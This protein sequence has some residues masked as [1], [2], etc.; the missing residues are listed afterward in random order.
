MPCLRMPE[1]PTL[2]SLHTLGL[3]TPEMRRIR[4]EN[5][6]ESHDIP[7]V[8]R[9]ALDVDPDLLLTFNPGHHERLLLSAQA[10]PCAPCIDVLPSFIVGITVTF[11]PIPTVFCAPA[12]AKCLLA[13]SIPATPSHFHLVKR[14]ATFRTFVNG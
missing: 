1:R 5:M 4:H 11:S 7:S 8:C 3:P 13:I 9:H 2:P 6:N 12:R 14:E 10:L